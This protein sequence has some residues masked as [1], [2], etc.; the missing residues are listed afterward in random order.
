MKLALYHNSKILQVFENVAS[1]VVQ[2]NTVSWETGSISD[3]E[4]LLLDD[5]VEVADTVTEELVNWD[6][7]ENF[8]KEKPPDTEE[9]LSRLLEAEKENEMNALAIMELA[10]LLLG[11]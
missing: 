6:Q 10:E 3:G 5:S 8:V 1:P 7:K 11:G 9:L 4:F 2:G